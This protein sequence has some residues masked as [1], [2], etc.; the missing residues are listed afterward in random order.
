MWETVTTGLSG[1]VVTRRA[2]VYRKTSDDQGHDLVAEGERLR[3]LRARGIPAAEVLTCRPGL[4]ETAEV[5]G[6][7]ASEHWP[8]ADRPRIVDAL[9]DFTRR[10]HA[11][12]VAECPFDRRLA[13][14]IPEALAAD[15][16]L[17]MLDA[18]RAGWDRDQLVARLVATRPALEDLVVCHGDLCLPNVLLDPVTCEVTGVVDV[19]RLG[20]AD[21]WAD[22]ALTTRSL[23]GDGDRFLDRY[24]IPLDPA[25]LEF[26]RLL[27][28]FF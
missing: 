12:P 14:T 8:M 15:V 19:G 28:E 16:A 11:L 20:V 17:D 9:A 24:G 22:L 4:L 10:L 2:G 6:R 23:V 21:R 25:K 18:E 1:A 13:V 7:P 3:W 27:D 5:P 26:Y